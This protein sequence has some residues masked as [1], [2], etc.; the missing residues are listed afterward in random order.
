MG[1]AHMSSTIPLVIPAYEP[2]ERL[3]DLAYHIKEAGLSPVIIVNDGSGEAYQAI[4]DEVEKILAENNCTVLKH[5]V[6]RGK[7]CA[8]KTA[9]RY[10]LDALP[11][12]VGVVTADSDGQHTVACIKHIMDALET[13]PS[14]LILGVRAFDGDAVP[15][16]SRI[17]NT[18]TLRLTKLLTG[19]DVQDTQTG[20]RG[21]PRS[22]MRE[23]LSVK[24][25][26]FE[27]E[28][29]MLLASV[30]KYPIVQIPICTIYDS[31]ENHQTHFNTL[32]DS[33]KIYHVLFGRFLR[34]A[35]SSAS[36]FLVDV[37]LFSIFCIVFQPIAS[38]LYIT[39]ATAGARSV[40]SVYNYL[41]N[42]KIV[43]NSRESSYR[44]APKYFALVVVQML[45][46]AFLVTVLTEQVLCSH[47]TAAKLMV[48]SV[49]FFVSYS[50][51]KNKIF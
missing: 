7:G 17:G 23:L 42:Q 48:D 40:S 1:E 10:I 4:F 32:T 12:A 51:Q 14:S 50:I 6:N 39:Y 36:A 27:F 37:V 41:V 19:L 16:R 18:I 45:C 3:V 13:Q 29:Q 49:L 21:I 2:D 22:F 35:L 43:F 33:A 26:R 44:S 31:K 8:L 15:W 9:F 11:E 5:E 24:G 38:V 28:M 20:L 46:S 47:P 34:F 30:G 25:E